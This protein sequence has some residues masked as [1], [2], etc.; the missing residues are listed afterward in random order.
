MLVINH[1]VFGTWS[2][3]EFIARFNIWDTGWYVNYYKSIDAGV[4]QMRMA[5]GS[6]VISV[7]SMFIL[8]LVQRTYSS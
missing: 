6:L 7:V 5:H 8:N 1:N 3:H 4:R 2:I